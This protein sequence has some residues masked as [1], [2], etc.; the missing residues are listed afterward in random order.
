MQRKAT[1]TWKGGGKAGSGIVSTESGAL[2][3]NRFTSKSRFEEEQGTNP[4]ELLAATHASCFSMKLSFVLEEAGFEPV[5][6]ETTATVSIDNGIIGSS[7]L[8]VKAKVPGMSEK[9][10]QE[11]AE[12]AKAN[13]PV[14]KALSIPIMM[15]AGLMH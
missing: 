1:S 5:Q 12:D 15:N 7:Q 6:I 8:A 3:N 11:C 4:E 10:F 13:C 9:Q 2:N 14:S